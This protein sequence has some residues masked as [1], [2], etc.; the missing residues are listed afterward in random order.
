MGIVCSN[1]ALTQSNTP[2]PLWLP[3]PYL[4]SESRQDMYVCIICTCNVYTV[5]MCVCACACVKQLAKWLEHQPGNWKVW[6]LGVV[7]VVSLS[8]L[9]NGNLMST[10]KANSQ[11]SLSHLVV[12]KVLWNFE[13]SLCETWTVPLRVTSLVLSQH[14][15]KYLNGA[16]ASHQVRWMAKPAFCT[17]ARSFALHW[18][19]HAHVCNE[20]VWYNLRPY[21][22]T[23]RLSIGIINACS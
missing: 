23:W 9:L 14:R 18:Y 20:G 3:V 19:V 8:K 1:N 7:A 10:G 15:L 2:L 6:C 22:S 5:S 12:L 13:F 16:Q 11:L 17:A 4:I 21:F